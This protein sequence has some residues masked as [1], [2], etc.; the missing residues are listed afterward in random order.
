MRT[1]MQANSDLL[2]MEKHQPD[3]VLTFLLLPGF[4]PGYTGTTLAGLGVITNGAQAAW[5]MDN[6][7][8]LGAN[9]NAAVQL[10]IWELLYGNDFTYV[11]SGAVG[12]L[13]TTY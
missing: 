1:Y 3:I 7:E 11:A 6:Y 12:S 4:L 8:G 2:L 13:Y 10:V 5:L 9:S